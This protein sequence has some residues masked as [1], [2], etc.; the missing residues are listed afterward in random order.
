MFKFVVTA[1]GKISFK[2]SAL[3]AC[4]VLALTTGC[5]SGGFKLTREYARFVNSKMI[6]LRIVL[7]IFT[8]IVFAITMLIDMVVFNTIDFWEGKVSQGTYDFKDGEKSF[9]AKHEILPGS[10]LKKSTILV[11]DAKNTLLQKVE[12]LETATGEVELYIDG[13]LRTRVKDIK[14][15]PVATLFDEKGRMIKEDTLWFALAGSSSQLAAK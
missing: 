1:F 15:L 8:S 14:S 10:N 12:L 13:Q 4:C 3:A 2:I 7:Y 9:H 11:T 5:A 6:I